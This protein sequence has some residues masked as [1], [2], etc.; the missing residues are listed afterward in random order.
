M[1]ICCFFWQDPGKHYNLSVCF[2]FFKIFRKPDTIVAVVPALVIFLKFPSILGIY[3][4]FGDFG[5]SPAHLA[6]ARDSL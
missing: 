3:L 4:G 1:G 2:W 6:S 5:F